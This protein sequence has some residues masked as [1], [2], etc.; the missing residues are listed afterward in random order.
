MQMLSS[1]H[2]TLSPSHLHTEHT[3]PASS[4][5]SGQSATPSQTCNAMFQQ[6]HLFSR[7]WLGSAHKLDDIVIY[8]S[9]NLMQ[10]QPWI[11]GLTAV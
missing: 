11:S 10:K 2:L 4:S 8:S 9:G 3:D 6:S 1:R 7:T 5:P